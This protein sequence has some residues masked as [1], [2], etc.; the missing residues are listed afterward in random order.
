MVPTRIG[1]VFNNG[2]FCGLTFSNGVARAVIHDCNLSTVRC[3]DDSA[4]TPSIYIDGTTN[5]AHF[6]IL[7]SRAELCDGWRVPSVTE[8]FLVVYSLCPLPIN[9]FRV[10]V[11]RRLKIQLCYY[12][13]E[14]AVLKSVAQRFAVHNPFCLTSTRSV[15]YNIE[16]SQLCEIPIERSYICPSYSDE[17]RTRYTV[18]V[19]TLELARLT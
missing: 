11:A 18:L 7:E 5:A 16:T 10:A 2:I 13:S 3:A 14:T 12:T 17:F 9:K 6:K 4:V 8:C 1:Q 15:S 19:K